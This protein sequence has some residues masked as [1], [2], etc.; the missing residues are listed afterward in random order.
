MQPK[1]VVVMGPE[2]LETLN[3]LAL[4][5]AREV[6]PDPGE[7]QPLTPSIDALYMP[8]IDEA[9]D[10]ESAKRA[11]WTAFRALG[12]WYAETCRRTNRP[13]PRLASTAAPARP[14]SPWPIFHRPARPARPLRE[15]R[16]P[17]LRRRYISS[18][19]L[20]ELGAGLEARV[21]VG[22]GVERERRGDGDAEVA[23]GEARQHGALDAPRGVRL[24]L[25]R[26]GA[27]HRAV[28][29][30]RACPSARAG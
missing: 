22:D 21:G 27:Q 17:P 29:A 8:N 25:E 16:P 18:D 14:A 6:A 10:E 2:A 20:A 26:A 12:E 13:L 23:R 19:D 7:V 9:L 30:R 15:F 3:E 11:F 24:V 4:P 5:L 28:D 1:I